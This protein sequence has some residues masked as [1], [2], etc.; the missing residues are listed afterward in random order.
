MAEYDSKV[1]YQFANRLYAQA[2][3]IIVT[4]TIIYGF[5]GAAAGF[6]GGVIL[7]NSQNTGTA[8]ALGLGAIF[9]FIGYSVGTAKAFQLK[10]QAQTALCQVRIEEN[11]RRENV[12]QV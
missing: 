9:G 3:S 11:T 4:H 12:Q 10:L 7:T 8:W 5:A 6:F 2:G 1:I